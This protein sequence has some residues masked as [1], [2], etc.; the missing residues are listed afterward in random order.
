[1]E[2]KDLQEK[3]M[4]YQSHLSYTDEARIYAILTLAEAIRLSGGKG[5]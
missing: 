4:S 5:K 3:A 2:Y 1:M